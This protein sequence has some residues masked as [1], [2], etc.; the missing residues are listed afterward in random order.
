MPLKELPG[1]RS[2]KANKTTEVAKS[3]GR[4]R[5]STRRSEKS[6]ASRVEDVRSFGTSDPPNPFAPLFGGSGTKPLRL[7]LQ[8]QMAPFWGFS[9][10]RPFLGAHFSGDWDLQW[11][12]D[13]DFEP[14]PFRPETPNQF[15]SKHRKTKQIVARELDTFQPSAQPSQVKAST[16]FK[17]EVRIDALSWVVS[18]SL[19]AIPCL[20]R[21][22]WGTK[23]KPPMWVPCLRHTHF[24]FDLELRLVFPTIEKPSFV[25]FWFLRAS[26]R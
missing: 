21:F 13:V 8:L 9:L 17:G 26:K 19:F 24:V 7:P 22:E 23:G 5:W 1:Y 20:G 3:G 12:Y 4:W 25:S 16:V 11:G 14:W 15:K 6:G 2:R 18:A 10:H